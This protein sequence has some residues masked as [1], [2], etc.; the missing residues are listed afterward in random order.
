M[1]DHANAVNDQGLPHQGYEPYPAA[2]YGPPGHYP[3]TWPMPGGHGPYGY[4]PYGQ[5][6]PYPTTMPGPVRAA[7]IIS[8]LF[9]GLGIGLSVLAGVLGKPELCGALVAGFL[10]AFF[11]ALFAF[12]Y[13]VN[14]NGLR[15]AAIIFASFGILW[16]LG[17]MAS[18]QPPGFL[19]LAASIAIV[20]LLSQRSAGA[21]F[22]RP[23]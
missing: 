16:G 8:W 15:I 14:G 12:G 4:H 3:P 19:G 1:D 2:P 13:T 10:P 22:N 21:W 17:G 7:Q 23:H 5:L 9:G 11:L 18:K 6:P 20:V